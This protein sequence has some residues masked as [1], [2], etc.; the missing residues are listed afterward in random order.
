MRLVCSA[1]GLGAFILLS[2]LAQAA[3]QQNPDNGEVRADRRDV[4]ADQREVRGDRREVRSDLRDA[5]HATD[6]AERR[7]RQSSPRLR[8]RRTCD[9]WGPARVGTRITSPIYSERRMDGRQRWKRTTDDAD[10]LRS[11]AAVML[12]LQ[13]TAS[14]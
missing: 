2:T 1:I 9:R 10:A 14:R 5:R 12:S 4:R 13:I 8:A 7:A 3:P 11:M 6:P